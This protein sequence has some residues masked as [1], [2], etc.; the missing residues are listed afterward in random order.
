MFP[1]KNKS[2]KL[3]IHYQCTPSE[4]DDGFTAQKYIRVNNSPKRS[5][6]LVGILNAVIFTVNDLDIIYGRPSDRRRYLDI[7][8]SQVNREYFRNL[9][10]YSKI[11]TQRNHLLRLIRDQNASSSEL[12]FWDEKLSLY[13]SNLINQRIQMVNK[14]SSIGEP[15]HRNMSGSDETLDCLYRIT[16][17]NKSDTPSEVNQSTFKEK[18]KECLSKDI[19]QGSTSFGPHRDD[20]LIQINKLDANRYASRGQSRTA[21]LS[22]KLAEAQ[23]LKQSRSSSPLLLLDDVLS[24]LDII[25]QEKTVEKILNY[26]QC[27]VTSAE[28]DSIPGS[29]LNNSTILEIKRGNIT[30]ATAKDDTY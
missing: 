18:L 15:I 20:L 1:V 7:L 2:T 14:I 23:F 11:N 10:E 4:N 13:G 28:S 6:A 3:E 30:S 25:R 26:E 12:E 8:I 24:E 21:I 29:L 22:L 5:S 16:T 19:A 9:R 17:Q 27:I